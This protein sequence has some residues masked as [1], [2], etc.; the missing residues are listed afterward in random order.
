[1]ETDLF[2]SLVVSRRLYAHPIPPPLL[3]MGTPDGLAA[4]SAYLASRA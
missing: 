4:L 2:P 3:D 1:M